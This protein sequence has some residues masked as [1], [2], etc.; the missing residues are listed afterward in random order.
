MSMPPAAPVR[1][2]TDRRDASSVERLLRALPDWF[3]IEES[4]REY[5]AD[6]ALKPTY[7]AEDADTG[8][9]LGALLVSRHSPGCAEIHLLA[10]DPAHHRRGIGR[11]LTARFEADMRADGVLLLEVKTQG[12]SM[13]DPG[14]A[15]TLAFYL[16]M[17]Y[18]PLEELH[19]YWPENPCLILVKPVGA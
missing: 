13:P 11:A 10:V 6:A 16:A 19:G 14:Y 5:V 8:A 7:L 3:G 18:L 12:P 17:G 9:V 4:V 2:V 15:A 1:I